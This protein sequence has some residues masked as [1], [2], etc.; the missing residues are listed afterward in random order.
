MSTSGSF[1]AA[2]GE[3][4]LSARVE[5]TD[6][7]GGKVRSGRGVSYFSDGRGDSDAVFIVADGCSLSNVIIG[8]DQIE[9]NH[10]L[11]L[12]GE[13]HSSNFTQMCTA[14]VHEQSQIFNGKQSLWTRFR[15]K[16]TAMALSLE[17]VR[18]APRTR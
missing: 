6:F 13:L 10:K 14:Q 8:A 12:S 7:D 11:F 15:S 1:P 16:A 3:S 5:V 9:G 2:A 17:E 4:T 18:T